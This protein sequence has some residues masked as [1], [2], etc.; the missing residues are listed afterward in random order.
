MKKSFIRVSPEG[1]LLRPARSV[2]FD[3]NTFVMVR[4]VLK[5]LPCLRVPSAVRSLRLRRHPGV[6]SSIIHAKKRTFGLKRGQNLAVLI[7]DWLICKNYNLF[8]PC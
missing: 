3:I 7:T 5:A 6:K 1:G 4:Q 2:T 8:I